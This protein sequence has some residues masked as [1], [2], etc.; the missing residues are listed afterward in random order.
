M[1]VKKKENDFVFIAGYKHPV[2][3]LVTRNDLDKDSELRIQV[4]AALHKLTSQLRKKVDQINLDFAGTVK[5]NPYVQIEKDYE[6]RYIVYCQVE[7]KEY[8]G[9][10]VSQHVIKRNPFVA[11]RLMD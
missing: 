3:S 7:D 4:T 1:R 9:T 8:I 5:L 6:D 11:S 10:T 2:E